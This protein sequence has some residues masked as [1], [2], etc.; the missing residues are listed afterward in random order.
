QESLTRQFD[1]NTVMGTADYIAPE[2]A[3]NLHDVDARADIYSLGATLYALIAGEPPFNSG[4]MAQK[5]LWHQMRDPVPL[6]QRRPECPPEVAAIVATMM[7]KGLGDR[8]QTAADVAEA[9]AP[10]AAEEPTPQAP[11]RPGG[12]RPAHPTPYVRGTGGPRSA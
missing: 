5:L 9:R 12:A 4:T 6:C 2:Q 11:P 7:A 1:E 8:Y 10:F 3:L